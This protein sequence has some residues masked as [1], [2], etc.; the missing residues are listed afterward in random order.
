MLRLG[1]DMVVKWYFDNVVLFI[2]IDCGSLGLF[3]IIGMFI[4]IVVERGCL[5]IIDLYEGGN[6]LCIECVFW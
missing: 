6:I 2:D 4:G 5:F 1:V 3:G